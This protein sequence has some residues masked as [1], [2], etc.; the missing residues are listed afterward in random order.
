[1]DV[2]PLKSGPTRRMVMWMHNRNWRHERWYHE[3]LKDHPWRATRPGEW[4]TWSFSRRKLFMITAQ[5]RHHQRR[6][7]THYPWSSTGNWLPCERLDSTEVVGEREEVD[8]Q[9]FFD[10]SKL[11]L[12]SI[13]TRH[14]VMY[15]SFFHLGARLYVINP[16]TMTYGIVRYLFLWYWESIQYPTLSD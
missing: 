16:C 15:C 8:Q 2:P 13:I 3:K 6:M 9:T 5:S 14:S 4:F 1:M 10:I 12:R 7:R 11:E